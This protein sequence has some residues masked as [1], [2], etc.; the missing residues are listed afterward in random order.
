MLGDPGLRGSRHAEQEQRAVGRERRHRGL[1]QAAVADIFGCNGGAVRRLAAHEIC[2]G[3]LRRELPVGRPLARITL[4]ESIELGCENVLGRLAKHGRHRKYS[5]CNGQAPSSTSRSVITV[6]ARA[7]NSAGSGAKSTR[8]AARNVE[9]S[10]ATTV[11]NTVGGGNRA[12]SV[13]RQARHALQ[14]SRRW[15]VSAGSGE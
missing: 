10:N 12:S 7:V 1:D 11:A 8:S 4:R 15:P 13:A 14:A 2:H 3:S 9:G 6:S 5:C